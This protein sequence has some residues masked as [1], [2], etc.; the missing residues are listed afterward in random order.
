MIFMLLNPVMFKPIEFERFKVVEF[1]HFEMIINFDK[2][3][4][5]KR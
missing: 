1:D 3:A 2:L 4:A 5:I